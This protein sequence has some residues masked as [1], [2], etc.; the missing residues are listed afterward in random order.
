MAARFAV[1][2]DSGK[3]HLFSAQVSRVR[4]CSY[5]CRTRTALVSF[6][7]PMGACPRCDGIGHGDFLIPG[8]WWRFPICRSLRAAIKGCGPAQTSFI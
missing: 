1:E 6:N 4:V 8:A 7:N 2:M 5:S 3:E